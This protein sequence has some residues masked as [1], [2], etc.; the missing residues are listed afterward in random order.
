MKINSPVFL[1]ANP[2]IVRGTSL[3]FGFPASPPYNAQ[4]GIRKIIFL[5]P[6][7]SH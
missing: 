5:F 2:R 1:L 7:L 4:K 6:F 3:S